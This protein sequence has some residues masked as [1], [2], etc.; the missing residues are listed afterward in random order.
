MKYIK[1][2]VLAIV[3]TVL[4]LIANPID[5]KTLIT[6]NKQD[7]TFSATAKQT[8]QYIYIDG[9]LYEVIYDDDGKIIQIQ[10]AD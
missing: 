3:V 2:S 8:V 7:F 5:A 4:S 9:D 1:L 10:P 6:T